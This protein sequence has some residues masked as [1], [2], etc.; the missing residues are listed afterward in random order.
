MTAVKLQTSVVNVVKQSMIVIYGSTV[1][2]TI[3][4]S[5]LW[6]AKLVNEL[7][8]SIVNIFL[9]VLAKKVISIR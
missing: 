5:L 1:V 8:V 9:S 6:I 4:L 2:L 3:K 7:C